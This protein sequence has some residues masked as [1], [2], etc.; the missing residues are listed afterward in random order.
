MNYK[1]ILLLLS[2]GA[3]FNTHPSEKEEEKEK[4]TLETNYYG[5]YL[6]KTLVQHR[7]FQHTPVFYYNQKLKVT[8]FPGTTKGF[9]FAGDNRGGIFV[10]EA[11]KAIDEK[12]YVVCKKAIKTADS[13]ESDIIIAGT[14]DKEI[15]QKFEEHFLRDVAKEY[16]IGIDTEELRNN[17][18]SVTPVAS[19]ENGKLVEIGELQDIKKNKEA[20]KNI[21]FDNFV[22]CAFYML[23]KTRLSQETYQPVGRVITGTNDPRVYEHFH[24]AALRAETVG[25]TK[26]QPVNDAPI[27][28]E[29][30]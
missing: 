5:G 26:Q 3:T 12:K 1:I 10:Q 25:Q 14:C 23:A 17:P 6:F 4:R 18:Y 28:K 11:R 7:A 2:F 9:M 8:S 24:L 22:Y 27:K 19:V 16:A 30:H 20:S 21:I 13:Q 15:C 29:G